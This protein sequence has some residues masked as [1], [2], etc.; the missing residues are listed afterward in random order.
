VLLAGFSAKLLGSATTHTSPPSMHWY[1]H[2]SLN[3][4]SGRDGILFSALDARL[5]EQFYHLVREHAHVLNA[6][7]TGLS[8]LPDTAE[9]FARTQAMW[10]F[11]RHTQTTPATL[12][13]P[14]R[15]AARDALSQTTGP[16]ALI[17]H[18]W[19]TLHYGRH[20]AKKDRLHKSRK[21]DVG[22][23]LG[24]ALLV[25]SADG[26]PL[27][28]MELRLR[29]HGELITTR[30]N[31][32]TSHPAHVDDVLDAMNAA[33]VWNLA[34][35]LIH[36]IDRAADSVGHFRTWHAAGHR[37]VVR[38]DGDRMVCWQKQELRLAKV[39]EALGSQAFFDAERTVR[40]GKRE[41]QLY[42]AETV[43]VLERPA[44]R[45]MNDTQVDIPGVP[46]T[47][48]LVVTR[49]MEGSEVLAE[50]L[51]LSNATTEHNAARIAQWYAWRWRIESF[52]K[53]LKDAGQDVESWEQE[54]SE[55]IAKR[56]CVAS[57]AC[58]SVWHLMREDSPQ[59]QEV[60]GLL[61]RL[62]GRQMKWGVRE[63]APALLAGLE[64]LLA[65]LD[66][67]TDYTPDQ[68]RQLVRATLPHLFNPSG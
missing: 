14:V 67:L 49:V 65:V 59:G 50:W 27:G 68:L 42:V 43:V 62:S 56:L 23:D 57:M 39:A 7:T 48:R 52:F 10:R 60:R 22:Y 66:V 41:G 25:D 16:V 13:E 11:F 34:R 64:K 38:V 29:T 12:L 37:F 9:T 47:L 44:R 53:L 19:S 8:A 5:R 17:V 45:R 51:L 33:R 6:I 36:V 21:G 63:T 3:L 20:T 4:V 26:R 31:P 58:L 15:E 46:L 32:A 18:D 28:P 30:A 61:V 2:R 40:V 24:T 35:P 54:S 55:A 1:L